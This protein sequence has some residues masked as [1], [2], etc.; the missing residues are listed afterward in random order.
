M[1]LLLGYQPLPG[2]HDEV[3]AQDGAIRAPF[4]RALGSIGKRTSAEFARSQSLAE[5]A[6]LNQ[7]V[8]FSVFKDQRGSEKIFPFC[9]LPRP[10]SAEGTSLQMSSA[11]RTSSAIVCPSTWPSWVSPC[12]NAARTHPRSRHSRARPCAARSARARGCRRRARRGIGGRPE[13]PA[14]TGNTGSPLSV[15]TIL[16]P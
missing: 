15:L 1:S 9:L 12:R 11:Q 5:R 14:P 13:A 4:V 6:L 3:F 8:T 16:S 2:T 10:I 7:G